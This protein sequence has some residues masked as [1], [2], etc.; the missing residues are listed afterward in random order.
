MLDACL[1][2]D[3]AAVVGDGEEAVLGGVGDGV[4]ALDAAHDGD[5][6]VPGAVEVEVPGWVEE[7]VNAGAAVVERRVDEVHVFAD[8]DTDGG[9]GFREQRERGSGCEVRF[10]RWKHVLLVVGGDGL[11]RGIDARFV[12]GVSAETTCSTPRMR[13]APVRLATDWRIGSMVCV[14]LLSRRPVFSGMTT[15]V[16]PWRARLSAC[17]A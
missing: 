12:E 2:E 14:L 4:S 5:V 9:G 8:G 1:A 13:V 3:A 16:A 17:S 10:K 7:Q 15:M 6:A 11:V